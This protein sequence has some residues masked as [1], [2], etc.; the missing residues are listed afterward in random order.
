[1]F[2]FML[3][4]TLINY[5]SF[6]ITKLSMVRLYPEAILFK[7]WNNPE[8]SWVLLLTSRLSEVKCHFD[9]SLNHSRDHRHY[10]KHFHQ[11]RKLYYV[12]TKNTW[13]HIELT[14]AYLPRPFSIQFCVIIHFYQ[15]VYTTALPFSHIRM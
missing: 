9:R 4:V 1:M 15:P 13:K 7:R 14:Y 6:Y 8:L 5:S 12:N 3:L 2:I 11:G 10:H